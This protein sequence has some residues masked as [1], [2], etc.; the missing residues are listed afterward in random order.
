VLVPLSIMQ[1]YRVG[2]ARRLAR[3]LVATDNVAAYTF[4]STLLVL[5]ATVSAIWV[6]GAVTATTAGLAGGVA[7]GVFGVLISHW[8]RDA[9]GLH[10]TPNRWLVGV[11]TLLVLGRLLYGVWRAWMAF[12]TWGGE[13]WA[14]SAGI[15]GSL[16][17][18][19][20]LVGYGLGFWIAVRW[21]LAR[22]RVAAG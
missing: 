12:D 22:Q 4:S 11:L 21:R 15:A 1:R 6:P 3:G 20:L 14:A 8:E 9:R 19:A 13:G 16:A 5:S 17:A 7:L 18:G 2:T 10:F